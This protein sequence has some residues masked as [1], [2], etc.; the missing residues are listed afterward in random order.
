VVPFGQQALTARDTLAWAADPI[1]A[2]AWLNRR[3]QLPPRIFRI[4]D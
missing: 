3:S 2:L 1:G 4:L